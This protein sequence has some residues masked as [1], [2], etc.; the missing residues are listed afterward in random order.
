[1]SNGQKDSSAYVEGAGRT[2]NISEAAKMQVQLETGHVLPVRA[3][4][5]QAKPNDAK[6]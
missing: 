1:M 4:S 3:S 2:P 5:L 6:P